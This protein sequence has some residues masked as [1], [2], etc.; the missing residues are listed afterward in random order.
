MAVLIGTCRGEMGYGKG[1]RRVAVAGVRQYAVPV[2]GCVYGWEG[3]PLARAEGYALKAVNGC[4]EHALA[5]FL[6]VDEEGGRA[7]G[8]RQLHAHVVSNI[9]LIAEQLAIACAALGLH[10]ACGQQVDA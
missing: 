8:H 5:H 7:V 4:E 9:R 10:D 6:A 1:G 3:A 2:G